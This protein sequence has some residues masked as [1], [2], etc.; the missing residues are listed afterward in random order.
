[1]ISQSTIDT[2]RERTDIVALIGE[3]VRL[4]KK[5]RSFMGLCPFHKEKTPSFSVN[6]ERGFFHCFGCKESGSAVDYV[7]KL[8][9]LSFPD[10]IRALAERIGIAIEETSSPQERDRDEKQRRDREDLFRV[11]ELCATFF[12]AQ[13]GEGG[14]PLR[15]IAQAE[16][17]R[18]GLSFDDERAA[19]AM[20]LFRVGYAPYGWEGLTRWLDKQG[21][22]A[23]VA[24]RVGVVAPRRT[25]SGFYDAFRHR[26]MFGV[27]DKSGRVVAFS[28]RALPEPTAEDLA[29]SAIVPM[30]RDGAS[31]REPPKYIN[32][33]ESPIYVKGETVFGLHQGRLAIR[34]AEKA[35]LVEGNFD[36]L[37][38]HAR[39]FSLAVAPLGTAFTEAQARL[40]KRYA[41]EVV[42]MFDGDRAGKKATAEAR[43][44][45]R[46]AGLSIK[47]ATL[48]DG[49][50]PDDHAR[51]RGVEAVRA[52][53]DNAKG[54]LEWLIDEMLGKMSA[55]TL[56]EKHARIRRVAELLAE[57]DDPNLRAMAKS[58][59]DRLSSQ[60][61]VDGESPGDIR[62]LERMI[63]KAL[64]GPRRG[65]GQRSG[66]AD[67]A[68]SE[69]VGGPIAL[70]VIGAILDFPELFDDPRIDDDLSA[71]DGD[72]VL[73]VAILRQ[74]WDSKKTLDGPEIL[75]LLPRAIH[76]FAVGRL[77]SP[78]FVQVAEARAELL[79][80]AEKLRQRSLT[81]DKAVKVRE[82]VR[83]QELGDVD[84]QDELLREI[85]RM[86]KQKRRLS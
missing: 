10:A 26:L 25:G 53:V 61:V 49:V 21:I 58:Y 27:L 54:M 38:L 62:A 44:P 52:L 75:D 59:A 66:G 22:G 37:S 83:A 24:E 12:E 74:V 15:A 42:V 77:A 68:R 63:T 81:G 40:V 60:L 13:L 82:L 64:S 31:E 76:S 57:E 6:Q 72:V 16:L 56:R 78:Q 19:E 5:G 65:E 35:V 34:E 45:A 11:S 18:R 46:V 32:S 80:N 7:M 41:P 17:T 1:M 29:R 51:T 33:P 43:K 36:V 4:T 30:Y 47:V 50:D 48:P 2:V 14:H 86:A 28:G 23:A 73:A 67:E 79:D 69:I 8:E 39:G 3:N 84:A 9:G 20:R 85:S 55:A 70:A 71:L